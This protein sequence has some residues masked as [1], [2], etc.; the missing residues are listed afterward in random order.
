MVASTSLN[1]RVNVSDACLRA[2]SASMSS[3]RATLT[4]E[5]KR[6]PSSARIRAVSPSLMAS[7]ASATSSRTLAHA[8]VQLRAGRSVLP[9]LGPL[10]SLPL[11]Q[12]FPDIR[13]L[14][15]PKNMGVAVGHLVRNL[16]QNLCHRE[17]APFLGYLAV[18]DD[19]EQDV[20][21]LL[22]DMAR[23]ALVDGLE[24]F[25]GFLDQIGLEGGVG[26]FAIPGAT[27][28]APEAAHEG[29]QG[30]EENTGGV[31]HQRSLNRASIIHK[32]GRLLEGLQGAC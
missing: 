10:D 25:V 5:K 22:A 3:S 27:A 24:G 9:A 30:F 8:S 12:G 32:G 28:L 26:L 23:L 1:R 29:E 11:A 7:S 18:E 20:P 4:S 31:S 2:S 21:E 6:S 16:L 17:L 14:C 15:R 19:L 13:H